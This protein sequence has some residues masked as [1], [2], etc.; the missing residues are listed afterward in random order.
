MEH[1]KGQNSIINCT[2][3]GTICESNPDY[4]QLT[5]VQRDINHKPF[6]SQ[7]DENINQNI[8]NVMII[9]GRLRRIIIL[10]YLI[11]SNFVL[12]YL[13]LDSHNFVNYNMFTCISITIHVHVLIGYIII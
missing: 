12:L 10:I 9:H 11:M 5:Y 13:Y 7:I 6:I 2:I 4:V 8:T 1:H 3:F